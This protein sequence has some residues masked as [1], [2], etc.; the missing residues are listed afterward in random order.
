MKRF[1]V[2][3]I[4]ILITGLIAGLIYNCSN[5]KINNQIV[6]QSPTT[7]NVSS[8]KIPDSITFAGEE[9]PVDLF[10]VK[11]SF[12]RELTVN[13]YWHSSTL[14]LL[15]KAPRY[16]P[17]IEPILKENGI[18][19]DFKYICVI[20]SGLSQA[21]SPDN[22]VGFW[23]FLKGTGKDYGLEIN[24]EVD[25]RYH[26][27]KSTEAACKYFNDAYE[28]YQNWTMVAASYNAGKRG[29]NRQVE[30]QKVENY[31]D[32]LLNEE[33]ERYIFRVL[34]MKAIFENP[35][36]YMFNLKEENLYPPI[37]TNIVK[38]DTAV[39]SWADF[40]FQFGIN[41]R[42]LKEFNPW[43]RQSYLTNNEGKTYK[44]KI[45]QK[46]YLKY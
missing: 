13:T 33:T 39:K 21:V 4:I 44:I 16:F 30:R 9:V 45:P 11:E 2:F 35:G 37:P 18:P 26:I 27:E 29:I 36:D 40:A 17:M 38:V 14:L 8:V 24:K 28:D 31:Y 22:A 32:L 25:E 43:L 23:Q 5:Q 46:E 7:I 20:E 42:I 41:Y 15:K 10:Y 19:D 3:I 1:F 34:A 6:E 12:D